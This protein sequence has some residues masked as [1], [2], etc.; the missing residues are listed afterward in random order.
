MNES[1]CLHK[2]STKPGVVT[3]VYG[4]VHQSL[5]GGLSSDTCVDTRTNHENCG[6]CG[7]KCSE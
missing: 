6:L 5:C 4:D 1:R 7:K 3:C 2:A